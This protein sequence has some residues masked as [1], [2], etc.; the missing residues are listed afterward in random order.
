MDPKKKD[1]TD[2]LLTTLAFPVTEAD[3]HVN[4]IGAKYTLVE[5]GDYE[6]PDCE[7]GSHVVKELLRDLGEDLCYVFRNFPLSAVHPNAQFAA[8]AAEAADAQGKFWLMHDRLFEHQTE[9]SPPRIRQLAKEISLDVHR[10][11]E[12]LRSGEPSRRVKEDQNGGTQS[13]V[14]GT[15][16]F[17]ANGGMQVGSYEYA[18]LLRSLTSAPRESA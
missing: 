18:P 17:F 13:G 6:C 11:E 10:F 7:M 3:H 4:S 14:V 15:P 5:Y 2:A 12:D 1:R 16:T 8:E 9:L